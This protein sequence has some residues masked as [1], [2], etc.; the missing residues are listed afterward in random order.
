MRLE[1]VVLEDKKERRGGVECERT[2][3]PT[4]TVVH[5]VAS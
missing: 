1:V 4:A 3:F 5:A 2:F